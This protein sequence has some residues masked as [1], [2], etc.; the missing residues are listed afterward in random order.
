MN[1]RWLWN[2]MG[3]DGERKKGLCKEW[4]ETFIT[5]TAKKKETFITKWLIGM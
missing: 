2:L 5:I 4:F 1:A 3:G